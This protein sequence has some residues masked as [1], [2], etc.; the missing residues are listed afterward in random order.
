MAQPHSH[1]SRLRIFYPLELAYT[2]IQ[3]ARIFIWVNK[4]GARIEQMHQVRAI[5][6]GAD[7]PFRLQGKCSQSL[8]LLR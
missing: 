8:A 6:F 5:R 7:S 3:N 4:A 2:A 1:I